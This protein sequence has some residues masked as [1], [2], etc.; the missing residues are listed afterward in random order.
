MILKTIS[1]M[2]VVV[3]LH[4]P[5]HDLVPAAPA[6]VG[7]SSFSLVPAAR[8]SY[9]QLE[10]AGQLLSCMSPTCLSWIRGSADTSVAPITSGRCSVQTGSGSGTA[11]CSVNGTDN[12]G[13]TNCSVRCD[14]GAICSAR[15]VSGA[16]STA[17]CSVYDGAADIKCSISRPSGMSKDETLC[18]VEANSAGSGNV[19]CSVIAASSATP[20]YEQRCS[21]LYSG[22]ELNFCSVRGTGSGDCS[23]LVSG[24]GSNPYTNSC[25]VDY[26]NSNKKCSSSGSNARCSVASGA[27]GY[28]TVSGVSTLCS[29]HGTGTCSVIGGSNGNYCTQ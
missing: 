20:P 9:L 28:C 17:K 25:S 7:V 4:L 27:T 13:A 19:T 5:L 29:V 10:P 3:A 22:G 15:D 12:G 26:P 11:T 23:V 1:L 8:A 2:T 18:S 14:S 21:T 6:E 16:T 24:G